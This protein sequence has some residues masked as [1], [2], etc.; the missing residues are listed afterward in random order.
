MVVA[1]REVK[2]QMSDIVEKWGQEVAE[3][4]F[5]QVPNYLLLINQFLD[6]E[7]RLSPAELLVLIQLIGSWW[8]RDDLPFPSMSTLSKRIGVSTRQ[9]QRAVNRLEELGLIKRTKR[10]SS[11]IISSNAYDLR[12]L[13]AVLN[14]VSKAFPNEY[15]RNVTP[16]QR[17]TL[18]RKKRAINLTGLDETAKA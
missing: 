11:G 14:E 10:R 9:I 12:P 17:T 5:A 2:S 18:K 3:R 7:S 15:P 8:K 6:E 1:L 16:Q 13:A 4:G